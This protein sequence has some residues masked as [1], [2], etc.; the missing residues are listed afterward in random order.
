MTFLNAIMVAGVAALTVPLVIHLFHRSRPKHIYWGAMHLLEEALL[1]NKR[2]LN[3]ENLLLLLIRCLIPALLAL[4][5]ARP[6]FTR[7]AELLG[8][9]SSSI[10][11]VLD[12][13]YS[14]AAVNAGRSTYDAARESISAVLDTAGDGSDVQVVLS[15]SEPE[16][17][18]EQP[19]YDRAQ[20]ARELGDTAAVHGRGDWN[21]ALETAFQ[22]LDK[23]TQP[24]RDLIWV[25]DFQKRDFADGAGT[26]FSR[27]A[28]MRESQSVKP[29]LVLYP[30]GERVPDNVA[31]TSLDY[32]SLLQAVGQP[33][34]VR[35]T[36]K[37]FGDREWPA[38]RVYFRV[39]EEEREVSE[40]RLAP[41]E[42]R[43][44]LFSHV[45]PGAGSHLVEV[46]ADADSLK[47]DNYRRASIPVWEQLSVLLV[48]GEP[49]NEALKGETDY[50]RLALQPLAGGA[51]LIR[52]T[53]V[54]AYQFE[55]GQLAGVQVA[56]L[57][58]VINLSEDR[59]NALK[60][61][62]RAGGGLLIFP[63]NRIQTAW[64]N[65]VLAQ[66]EG[67]A[68]LRYAALEGGDDDG[69]TRIAAQ[70]YDNPALELF[71]EAGNGRLSDAQIRVWY[72]SELVN[73]PGHTPGSMIAQLDG[74]AP[75]LAERSY[76]RG[77]V[78]Q[79]VVP[80]DADWSNL[81]L[82]PFYLPLMQR[83]VAHLATDAVP[84]RNFRPGQP[85]TAAL[86]EREA[87][88][89]M[90]LRRPDGVMAPVKPEKAGDRSI[91]EYADTRKPGVYTL[92][93][94]SA[95]DIHFVVQPDVGES[96]LDRLS[97]AELDDV[98]EKLGA[99]VVRSAG[100]FRKLDRDRRFGTEIWREL[101]WAV[102][103]LLFL[104]MVLQQWIGRKAI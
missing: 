16:R 63:G 37:N 75:F 101:F 83:L 65:D 50:L 3:L 30:V 60:E 70:R 51:N 79:C 33:F 24:V 43:Q 72:R 38:L 86:P 41:R 62:V 76:G 1:E 26:A 53:E 35:A 9:G 10:A 58:N 92:K 54:P 20:L 52:F 89:P 22:E 7:F 48:N 40:I 15:G 4:S 14:M 17:L 12:D 100:E 88:R 36:V 67:L 27:L 2:R 82:R 64:Y 46:F 78:I 74:G 90:R 85:I 49:S 59:L 6:V 44:V 55:S 61:F 91:V 66:R 5:M 57:A 80:C 21:R 56:V 18:R 103:A 97:E 81:P 19:V 39:N 11:F 69:G 93:A 87:G 77:R 94:E 32:S 34:T 31:V 28:A 68:P 8:S 23:M 42:E 102:L 104:E 25:S 98:A 95:P 96:D 73:A 29:R 84:P 45:F 13:S 71:N 47:A 99:S